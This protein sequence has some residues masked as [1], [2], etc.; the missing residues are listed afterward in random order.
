MKKILLVLGVVG[1]LGC[2]TVCYAESEP[3]EEEVL[4]EV[5]L[6]S[7]LDDYEILEYM[8]IGKSLW[9]EQAEGGMKELAS[10]AMLDFISTEGLI[11]EAYTPEDIE[12]LIDE[13]YAYGFSSDIFR[14]TMDMLY[15]ESQ[16]Y[17]DALQ[18]VFHQ[19][20]LASEEEEY[21]MMDEGEVT[22]AALMY[23]NDWYGDRTDDERIALADSI[24]GVLE[25]AEVDTLGYDGNTMAQALNDLYDED[26]GDSVLYLILDILGQAELYP[27]VV[28]G[29]VLCVWDAF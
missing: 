19:Q 22:R 15:I 13:A 21:Q 14:L 23:K 20:A 2:Q 25:Y 11:E 10:E 12:N 16:S 26:A 8:F 17:V 1:M 18:E 28:D 4:E 7:T 9:E 6:L 27:S 24:L 3:L 29:I 5:S